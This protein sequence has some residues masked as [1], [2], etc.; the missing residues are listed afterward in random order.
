LGR[1][2]H[3]GN[4]SCGSVG[5]AFGGKIDEFV[6]VF[7][8]LS[9][10]VES[11]SGFGGLGEVMHGLSRSDNVCLRISTIHKSGGMGS[12]SPRGIVGTMSESV[13]EDTGIVM[14]TFL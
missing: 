3:D 10:N 12:E 2:R 5:E 6:A 1:L 13:R 11:A 7:E 14:G 4:P 9:R 8:P